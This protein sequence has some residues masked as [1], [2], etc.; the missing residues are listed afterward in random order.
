MFRTTAL[1][2]ALA[3][4]LML[5]T[6]VPTA[7]QKMPK[8]LYP[9]GYTVVYHAAYSNIDVD[10]NWNLDCT[11]SDT[12]VFHST[13]VEQ[14]G[15][16]GGSVQIASSADGSVTFVLLISQYGTNAQAQAAVADLGTTMLTHN[17]VTEPTVT[18]AGAGG[19]VA[20]RDQTSTSAL[21]SVAAYQGAEEVEAA[22]AFQRPQDA[23]W[24]LRQQLRQHVA[25]AVQH[26]WQKPA[27]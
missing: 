24:K 26:P 18:I 10:C 6:A 4:S 20:A 9:A 21:Y 1:A 3:A 23:P 27:Q 2:A 19:A 15:R 13:T 16:L 22:V 25:W 14:L 12:P 7:A 11:Q 17:G 8:A 5:F